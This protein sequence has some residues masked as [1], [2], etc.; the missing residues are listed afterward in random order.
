[1]NE[2]SQLNAHL[3]NH[4]LMSAYLVQLQPCGLCRITVTREAQQTLRTTS[5]LSGAAIRK[6]KQ[7]R[8]FSWYQFTQDNARM[9]RTTG[10]SGQRQLQKHF[11]AATAPNAQPL[12]ICWQQGAPLAVLSC[13][14]CQLLV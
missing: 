10:E 5:T 3:D 2:Q 8:S 14:L 13:L 7:A 9:S 4:M 6:K 1:M 12:G 11:C